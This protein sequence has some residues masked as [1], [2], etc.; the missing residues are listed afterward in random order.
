MDPI[1]IPFTKSQ[2]Q[3]MADLDL[4]SKFIKVQQQ[5]IVKTVVGNLYDPEHEIW[6]WQLK[7]VANKVIAIPPNPKPDIS[8][9]E[10]AKS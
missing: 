5:A 9:S 1:E 3:H 7:V 2:E 10:D 6:N 8:P 4:D